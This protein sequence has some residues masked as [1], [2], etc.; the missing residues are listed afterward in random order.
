MVELTLIKI[1]EDAPNFKL[2]DQFDN[3]ISLNDFKGKKILL[4]FHPL[5]WTSVC[6]D[7]MLSIENNYQVFED[8]ATVPLGVSVDSTPSKKAWSDEMGLKNLKLISDFWPHGEVSMKYEN[9]IDRL[10]FSGRANVLIDENGKIVWAKIY[11][12]KELPD[13]NEVLEAIKK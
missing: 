12:I 3:E 6:R 5:A 9:F 13:I 7:Q 10:G 2:K 8:N 11:P 1:G 4:S